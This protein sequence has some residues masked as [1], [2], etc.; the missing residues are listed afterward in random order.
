ML[1]DEDWAVLINILFLAPK[2][3]SVTAPVLYSGI[4]AKFFIEHPH[5]KTLKIYVECS[6][7]QAAK[8]L[9]ICSLQELLEI[10]LDYSGLNEENFFWI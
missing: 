6:N 4:F 1:G 10:R 9:P 7:F 2:K 5:R 3:V 8:L